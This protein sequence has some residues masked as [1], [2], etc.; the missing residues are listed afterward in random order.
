MDNRLIKAYVFQLQSSI[1]GD[2]WIEE[3]FN[4]KL[5]SLVE[6]EPFIRPASEVHSVAEIV[7]HILEWRLSVLNILHGG[8]KTLTMSAPNNWRSNEE[9]KN[10]GWQSLLAAFY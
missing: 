9:L 10:V 7:S 8:K 1:D 6:D 3:T 2:L 4:K 5:S